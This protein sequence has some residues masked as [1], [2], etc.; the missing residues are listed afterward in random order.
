MKVDDDQ[1]KPLAPSKHNNVP[2]LPTDAVSEGGSVDKHATHVFPNLTKTAY[3]EPRDM[4][5]LLPNDILPL[6]NASTPRLWMPRHDEIDSFLTLKKTNF[7]PRRV[8]TPTI[9]RG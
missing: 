1:T 3:I 7:L 2:S 5:D 4:I 8:S 9:P 6:V